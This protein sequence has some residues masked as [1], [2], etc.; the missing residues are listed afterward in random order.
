M[1]IELNSRD[2]PK[3]STPKTCG[4]RAFTLVDPWS[5]A[6]TPVKSFLYVIEGST[7]KEK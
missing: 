7:P 6:F 1:I 4:S 5:R 3:G 2:E